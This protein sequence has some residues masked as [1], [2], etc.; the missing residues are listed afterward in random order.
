MRSPRLAPSGLVILLGLSLACSDGRAQTSSTAIDISDSPLRTRVLPNGLEIVVF[1]DRTVPL[2][3]VEFVARLGSIYE[4]S[5]DNGLA[6]VYEHLFFRS[7]EATVNREDYLK[8][9]DLLGIAYNGSTH[10]ELSGFYLTAPSEHLAVVLRYTRDSAMRP[11]FRLAEVKNEIAVV[12]AEL[13]RAEANPYRWLNERASELLFHRN[14]AFKNPNG[15]AASV[16]QVTPEALRA[17]HA[18]YITPGNCALIVTGDCDPDAVFS[19]VATLFGDWPRSAANL[20]TVEPGPPLAEDQRDLRESPDVDSVFVQLSWRGPSVLDETAATY[21]ADVLSFILRQSESRF[22]RALVD[23]GLA[24]AVSVGYYTQRHVG[25]ITIV[26]RCP[27]DKARAAMKTLWR[28]LETLAAPGYFSDEE[29]ENAKTLIA[30][31][32]LFD[33]EKPTEYAESLAFWWA[34]GGSQYLMSQQP[35]YRG[36]TRADLERYIKRYLT[37]RPCVA[38]ALVPQGAGESGQFTVEDLARP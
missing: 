22:Q 2:V 27:T 8:D 4:T 30:A 10:E 14:P 3:T 25:P 7:N 34:I 12:Q 24:T 5:S 33:R 15:R 20:P 1:P 32:E 13:R 11:A 17:M 9:I 37:G 18:R 26:L 19:S 21:A 35:A 29:L 31:E 6:H 38:L 36:T 16:A 23:A 28:E